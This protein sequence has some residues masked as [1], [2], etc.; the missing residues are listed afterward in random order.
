MRWGK[1][2]C[3]PEKES[4]T[5]VGLA[6]RMVY[7]VFLIQ[8]QIGEALDEFHQAMRSAA[9]QQEIALICQYEIGE[10]LLKVL[11]SYICV[12]GFFGDCLTCLAALVIIHVGSTP[13]IL[14]HN[15][16]LEF[17]EDITK[18]MDILKTN[19]LAAHLIERVINCYI[20]GT[21]SNHCPSQGSLPTAS[22]TFY[23]KLPSSFCYY[24]KKKTFAI[25]S[26]AIA[27]I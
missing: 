18:L 17:H 25:L 1:R 22:L 2:F 21:R 5:L 23:F 8:G 19:L 20:T 9:E 15:T 14:S 10:W 11:Y 12:S 27:M 3:G 4:L 26:S 16:W 6:L 13:H 7:P 24:S